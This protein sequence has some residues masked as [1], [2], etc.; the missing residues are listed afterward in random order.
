MRAVRS[1]FS[2]QVP[3]RLGW[4]GS[5][6]SLAAADRITATVVDATSPIAHSS[7]FA[8]LVMDRRLWQRREPSLQGNERNL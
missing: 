1:S 7:R 4:W 6:R 3:C 8:L 5:G 2:V